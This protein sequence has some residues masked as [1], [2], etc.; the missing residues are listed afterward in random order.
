MWREEAQKAGVASQST[1]RLRVEEG[2]PRGSRRP[3][4]GEVLGG[5][6]KD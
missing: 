3:A 4:H 6:G 1:A 2:R 5:H